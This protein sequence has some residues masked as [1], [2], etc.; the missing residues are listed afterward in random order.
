MSYGVSLLEALDTLSPWGQW[1]SAETPLLEGS[2]SP[3]PIQGQPFKV[4][5]AEVVATHSPQ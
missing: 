4:I 5:K 1:H 2:G 3:V